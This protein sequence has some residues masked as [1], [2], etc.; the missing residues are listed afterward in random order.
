MLRGLLLALL[1]TEG[2]AWADDSLA[3][4][5]KAVAESDYAA[6]R[7]QRMAARDA[8]GRS[9]DE[10]A[11]LYRLTGIVSAA[12][13]DTKAATEA[14]SRL[15]AVSPKA[16]LPA[17]TSPK[18]KRPFDAAGRYVAS[19]G[20]LEVKL[21]TSAAP[22]AI[23]VELVGDPLH[24][25]A[26]ARVAFRVDGGAEQTRESAVAT[27][28]TALA[29]PAGR[30]IDARVAV[31]DDHGNRLVELGTRDVPVV[32]LGEAR[33][34]PVVA[35]AARPATPAVIAPRDAAP[36]GSR[37]VYLRWWPYAAG[38]VVLGG[39]AGYFG[40]AAR[41]DT[42]ALNRLN[43][44][45]VHHTFREARAVEDRGH[46]HALYANI[47]LGAAGAF[48]LTAGVMYLLAPR[49]HVEPRVIAVATASGGAFVLGGK[50]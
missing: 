23:T 29:L 11:E 43:A 33:P 1:L 39:A 48:A 3:Q 50:F 20:G 10:T 26:R 44:D 36:I 18:I 17:G 27:R 47:G 46:R 15:L 8:G 42:D 16:A 40:L 38:A 22:P 32:I 25:V 37:P 12:L 2:V 19:H 30:R 24:M 41:T 34:A 49:A 45:S 9:P 5:R 21:D 7:S 6:A 14:F 13:G 31:L 28:R 35:A 4:A